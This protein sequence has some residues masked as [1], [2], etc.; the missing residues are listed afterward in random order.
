MEVEVEVEAEA[1]SEKTQEAEAEANG[2][3]CCI[4]AYYDII[5]INQEQSYI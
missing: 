3:H 1:V 4:T 5:V 2:D